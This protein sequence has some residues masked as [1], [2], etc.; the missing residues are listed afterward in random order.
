[1]NEAVFVPELSIVIPVYNVEKYL[2]DCLE[3]IIGPN[4]TE[5]EIVLVDD[6]S[7]DSSGDIC[8]RYAQKYSSIRVFHK[9]NTGVSD[10]RNYGLKNANGKYIAFVDSDDIIEC[11]AIEKILSW[12]K[13]NDVDLCFLNSVKF[14]SDMEEEPLDKPF[15]RDKI[16][17]QNA[18]DVLRYLSTL[19]KYSGSVWAKLFKREFL[20]KSNVQFPFG[21]KH[22]EDLSFVRTVLFNAKSFDYLPIPYYKYRMSRTD[23]ATHSVNNV[24]FFDLFDFVVESVE[25]CKKIKEI[26]PSKSESFMN[27]VAYEYSVIL[28]HSQFVSKDRKK[29]ANKMLRDYKW[30]LKY[31]SIPSVKKISFLS[32][33][34]GINLTSKILYLYMKFRLT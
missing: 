34:F 30:V 23:S 29:E 10:S 22:G 25:E 5:Y 1:M 33:V 18:E 7:S 21:K 16:R 9:K 6:G 8:D 32:K 14:Y 3:S 2:S 24:S 11:G 13:E 15:D 20:L 27:F 28:W 12:T 19:N 31:S 17:N 4:I 26:S